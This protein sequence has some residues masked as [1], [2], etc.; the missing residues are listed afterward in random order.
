MACRLRVK[1]RSIASLRSVFEAPIPAP[2]TT[3]E[4]V[5]APGEAVEAPGEAVEA[6]GEAI[7]AP[8]EAIEAPGE[9]IEAPDEA[10]E[11]PGDPSEGW[12]ASPRASYSEAGAPLYAYFSRT[13]VA[14]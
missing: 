11:A 7:E 10:V 5:E 6:P 2:E 4:A 8:G 9:A 14:P 1:V 13:R 12:E 3:D